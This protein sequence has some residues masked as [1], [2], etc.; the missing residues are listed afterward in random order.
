MILDPVFKSFACLIDSLSPWLDQ[1]VIIGGWAHRLYRFHPSAQALGYPP[2]TTLDTDV[3]LPA[4][5]QVK[6]Q[7]IHERLVANGF[8]EEFLG[9]DQ[10]PATHYHLGEESAGFYAEFLTPLVGSAYARTGRTNTTAQVGGVSTQKLRHI[11]LLLEAPWQVTL[12]G[13]NGF[14]SEANVRI[15]NPVAFVVQKLLI[16]Q[17][18]TALERAKDILYIHDTL[19][20]FGARLTELRTEWLTSVKPQ[21]HAKSAANAV[22]MSSTLFGTI[23]DSIR[24]AALMAAGRTLSP[25][26]IREACEFGLAR[27]LG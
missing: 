16:H 10:P 3:A 21:L 17:K 25:E 1:V 23:G 15:A 22:R 9:E 20:L 14:S 19:Q 26:A 13:A 6:G 7:D 2:L 8:R 11:E 4:R 12:G 24:A 18:R 27:I 5:L